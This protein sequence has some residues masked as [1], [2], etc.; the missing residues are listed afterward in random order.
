MKTLLD[1]VRIG[2]MELDNRL[3]RSATWEKMADE[4]G[5]PTKRLYDLYE[6]LSRGGAGLIISSVTYITED[7]RS[8]PG[9]LGFYGDDSIEEFRV[10]TDLAHRNGRRIVMQG[11]FATRSDFTTEIG[12]SMDTNSVSVEDIRS[13]V[14]AFGDAAVRARAA[15]FDGIQIHAA[16]GFF[17]SRFLVPWENRRTDR[18]GGSRENMS[19]FIIEI[20]D[21]IRRRV[22]PE[23][24]VLVKINCADPRDPEAVFDL[25]RY[26]CRQLSERGIDAIELSGNAD[27]FGHKEGASYSESVFREYASVVAEEVSCPVILV[28]RNRNPEVMEDILNSSKIEL[29]SMSRPFLR[30]PSI[31]NSWKSEGLRPSLCVSC[32]KCYGEEVNACIFNGG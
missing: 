28:G 7:S 8:L 10:L 24:A 9:Q 30:E 6:E 29:F 25:C 32:N 17:I 15:G 11:N 18:Y 5:H 19:R 3:V 31:V 26:A 22:G 1:R 16:H 12:K 21:E 2:G 13:V 23:F 27:A 14:S 20:Y 4:K